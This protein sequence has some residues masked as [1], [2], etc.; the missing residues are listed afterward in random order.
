MII[1]NII[2]Y[3]EKNCDNVFGY[4]TNP[5]TE[6][7]M[8]FRPILPRTYIVCP[9]TSLLQEFLAIKVC[10][11]QYILLICSSGVTACSVPGN[12]WRDLH[13]KLSFKWIKV[14]AVCV[15]VNVNSDAFLCVCCSVENQ[16]HCDFVKLRNMLIR[17]HMH[18]L[19]DVTC[20]VHYENY[21]AHCIQEM[22]RCVTFTEWL[23]LVYWTFQHRCGSYNACL[24]LCVSVNLRRITVR[25]VHYPSCLCQHQTVRQR[26]SS[27]WRMTRYKT[28]IT[29]TK[30]A[31]R[32]VL[33]L[34][35]H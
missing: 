30:P 14:N 8:L 12:T 15:F 22:T 4:I 13:I 16:S 19:K 11:S 24:C 23:T 20:D 9:N 1:I 27:R 10:T 6:V 29:D 33:Q 34:L 18:D 26:N 7:C 25:T 3:G 21:R 31:L 5:Y 28:I 35:G 32:S 17:S 2:C